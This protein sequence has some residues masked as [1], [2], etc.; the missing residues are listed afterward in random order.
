MNPDWN[1][2]PVCRIFFGDTAGG[3]I[4]ATDDRGMKLQVLD[5]KDR[6]EYWICVFSNGVEIERHNCRYISSIIW[7]E[8]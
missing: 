6:F 4:S 5:A 3:S 8:G 7:G 1:G 2:R